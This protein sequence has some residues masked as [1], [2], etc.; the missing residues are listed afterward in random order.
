MIVDNRNTGGGTA[1][2]VGPMGPAGPTGPTGATG[3]A[4]ADGENGLS[5]IA[6]TSPAFT[7]DGSGR[8]TRID[9]FETSYKLF[10]YD[11]SGKLSRIDYHEVGVFPIIRKT[12]NYSGDTLTSI[13]QTIV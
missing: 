5:G 12:F 7:F 9:Y 1:G 8:L 3:P 11:G 6:G 2:P 4:G 10:T 13:T